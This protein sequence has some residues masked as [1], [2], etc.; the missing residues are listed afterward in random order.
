MFVSY[1]TGG[2]TGMLRKAFYFM[3]G[4]GHSSVMVFF[5][6]SGFLVGGKALERLAQGSFSWQKYA[7]DRSSRLYA[8][9]FLALVLGG[10]L[11]Y[12]GYQYLNR[13]GLYDQSFS[14][15][16]PVVNH[17]FHSTLTP[18][19]FGL[20]LVMCQTVLSPVFGSNGPLWSLANEFWYYL[21]GPVLFA[22]F[23]RQTRRKLLIGI[24]TLVALFCFLPAGILVYFL[25]WLFGASLYFL[26]NRPLLPL[27]FS[28]LLFLSSFTADRLQFLKPSIL[29]DFL[30]GISFALVINSAARCPQRLPGNA[31][32]RKAANFSYS[33]Y[34]CHFPILAFLLSA[35]FQN[36]GLGLR[37]PLSRIQATLF[38]LVL[39]L[40]YIGC[41]LVSLAT[42]L[43]TPRIRNWLYGFMKRDTTLNATANG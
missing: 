40:V 16:I 38:I 33:V 21:A 42:E 3:T 25:I 29:G 11:D 18:A 39:A 15:T 26:N 1:G 20:N 14:G 4:F 8:V 31:L 24:A 13:F 35:L 2:A 30:I 27:W 6:M 22:L 9:Y 7:V 34:L 37:G 32:S 36:T 12:Y 43:Q 10:F 41:F 28:M 17:D 19:N 23:F 5:V